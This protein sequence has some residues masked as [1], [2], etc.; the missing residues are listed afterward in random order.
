MTEE[1]LCPPA[2]PT[3]D[4]AATAAEVSQRSFEIL[5]QVQSTLNPPAL[6]ADSPSICPLT[7]VIPVFNERRSLPEVLA[8]IDE[9]LPRGTQT[10]IVDDASTDGTAEWL[11][12]LVPR[13][14][15]K[16]IFRRRNHGKG[17]AV[18]LGIR[19]SAGEVVAI[20]DAD[21]EY[22]PADLLRVIDPIVQGHA[23]AVYGSRYLLAGTDPSW[24][25]R[26]GNWA[27]TTASNCMTGQ[28]LTDME[29]CHKAFCGSLIRSM[30]IRQCRFG[31]EPEITGRLSIRG[32]T[33]Q[34]VATGY[35]SRGYAEGKKI[36][37]IDG[38]VA[39]VCMWRYRNPRWLTNAVQ[40][41]VR[42]GGR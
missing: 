33:I 11:A 34:E 25:H 19:H 27:L 36:T 1:S 29:T 32:V 30:D 26:F 20:Q 18:R 31:F 12:S 3:T 6:E 8:R 16:T 17:S 35:R 5:E 13:P 10:I 23:E 2:V 22:D 40:R 41:L 4:D 15:R 28:R 21:S 42:R 37:W 24:L 14:N 7:V 9:V 39:F 38:I